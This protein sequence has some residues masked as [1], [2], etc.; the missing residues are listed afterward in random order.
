M[1]I[2]SKGARYL[3]NNLSIRKESMLTHK[4]NKV[5]NT[6]YTDRK[7]PKFPQVKIKIIL[8]EKAM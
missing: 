3:K 8:I 5:L 4:D 7:Q 6:A 2:A 1:E